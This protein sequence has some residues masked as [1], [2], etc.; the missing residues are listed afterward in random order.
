MID[1]PAVDFWGLEEEYIPVGWRLPSGVQMLKHTFCHIPGVGVRSE[2][3][4]WR[5]GILCWEDLMNAASAG[6]GR[7]NYNFMKSYIR[8]SIE[9]LESRNPDY[10]ARALPANQHW[11]F[12]PDFRDATAYLDIETSGQARPMDYITTVALYDGES[13]R[14][15]VQGDNLARF[16]EDIMKFDVIVTYNGKCF[17]VPFINRYFNIA[18]DKAHIDLMYVLRSLGYRGGLKGCE[19]Q[20]GLDRGDLDGVDGYMAVLLWRDFEFNGN[21]RALETLLA[22]NTLDAV[23]LETLMVRAYNLKVQE[24]P[25]LATHE[26]PEPKAPENPFEPDTRTLGRIRERYNLYL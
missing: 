3:D 16:R 20:F 6:T 15:Y 2:R 12:F 10:F 19:K 14:H 9:H 13:V 24:T 5:G 25:F 18:L 1:T 22:Y 4:L 17:D 11:R 21:V 23:N 26:L 7:Y 8:E